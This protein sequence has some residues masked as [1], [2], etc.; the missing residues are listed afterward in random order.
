MKLSTYLWNYLPFYETI[1]LSKKL[2]TYL[3][4]S[5]PIYKLIYLS[6][7][8]ATCL[9]NYLPIYKPIYLSIKLATCLWNYLPIYKTINLSLNLSTYLWNYLPIYGVCACFYWCPFFKEFGLVFP[10]FF[11]SPLIIF[12]M[13]HYRHI[14]F[15]EQRMEMLNCIVYFFY[16]LFHLHHGVLI[17]RFDLKILVLNI[18]IIT[19]YLR[20]NSWREWKRYFKLLSI[21]ITEFKIHNGTL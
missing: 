11:Q 1:Y 8:L 18:S 14:V 20:L 2:L 6:M 13:Q 4:N 16:F 19:E 7:K 15:V 21:Y 9:W 5:L 12:T 10:G 17:I 3:L